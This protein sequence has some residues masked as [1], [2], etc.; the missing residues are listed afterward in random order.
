M[1]APIRLVSFRFKFNDKKSLC[2][3]KN[4]SLL[5]HFTALIIF[6]TF[7]PAVFRLFSNTFQGNKT[8]LEV[9]EGNGKKSKFQGQTAN[10]RPSLS[11]MVWLIRSVVI[12]AQ[13]VF[14]KVHKA[15]GTLFSQFLQAIYLWSL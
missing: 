6:P 4:N 8:L 7:Q 5:K 9:Q 12:L 2:K 3:R 11:V 14:M 15:P 13:E 10:I 1:S